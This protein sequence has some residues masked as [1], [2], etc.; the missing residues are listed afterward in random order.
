MS[1]T[2]MRILAALVLCSGGAAAQDLNGDW[3]GSLGPTPL[4]LIL[5]VE[6]GDGA[7][8]EATLA[9]IDQSPTGGRRYRLTPSHYKG[10]PS[11]FRLRR[12]AARTA[13]RSRLTAIPSM[14]PGTKVSRFP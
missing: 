5:H 10:L 1:R 4:R 12:Y 13:A 9:S 7:T 6:K 11:S 3:Q 8:W 2:A 14:A